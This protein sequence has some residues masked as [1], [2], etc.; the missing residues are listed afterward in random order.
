MATEYI[1]DDYTG[2]NQLIS[3]ESKLHNTCDIFDGEVLHYKC[4]AC[5]H[6]FWRIIGY[7]CCCPN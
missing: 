4:I 6:K 3:D 5:S 7:G 1:C 2:N